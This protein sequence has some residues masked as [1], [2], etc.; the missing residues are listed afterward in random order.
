MKEESLASFHTRWL[1]LL[2][3]FFKKIILSSVSSPQS[4][5]PREKNYGLFRFSR[6]SKGKKFQ[7]LLPKS[8]SIHLLQCPVPKSYPIVHQTPTGGSVLTLLGVTEERN[9]Q[10]TC[11]GSI[12]E[13]SVMSKSGRDERK[14]K[15]M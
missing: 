9:D 7:A 11:L 1:V 2:D 3:L 14:K 15:G 5:S 12:K 6:F 10:K 8:L 4:H 13:E